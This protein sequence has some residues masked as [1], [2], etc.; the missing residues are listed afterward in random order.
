MPAPHQQVPALGARGSMNNQALAA[1]GA[2]LAGGEVVTDMIGFI[3]ERKLATNNPPAAARRSSADG[4]GGAAGGRGAMK[5][6][7]QPSGAGLE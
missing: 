5:I 1:G 4:G 6:W 7:I 2:M 3:R